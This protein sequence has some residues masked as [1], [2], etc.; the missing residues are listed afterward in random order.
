MWRCLLPHYGYLLF[1]LFR[2]SSLHE[3]HDSEIILR[4]SST[5]IDRMF[6]LVITNS[7]SFKFQVFGQFFNWER[8]Q[9]F[10]LCV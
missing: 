10:S 5:F 7:M 2:S 1:I 4:Q 8:T 9:D 6:R 3:D